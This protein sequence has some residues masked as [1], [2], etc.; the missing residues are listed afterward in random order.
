MTEGMSMA[1]LIAKVESMAHTLG[2]LG[3][4][5]DESEI[6]VKLLHLTKRYRHLISAWDNYDD[7][8]QTR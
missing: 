6:M 2:D 1:E 7:S 3:K 5:I 8:R 4:I